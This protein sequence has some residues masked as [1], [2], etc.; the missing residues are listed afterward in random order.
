MAD[1]L[2]VQDAPITITVGDKQY[3][4]PIW[5]TAEL[6]PILSK[7]RNERVEALRKV[8]GSQKVIAR[9]AAYMLAK[10]ETV[11]LDPH[12]AH[13]YFMS[14]EGVDVC[15]ATSLKKTGVPESEIKEVL[16][17]LKFHQKT[18]LMV[19]VAGIYEPAEPPALKQDKKKDI[20]FGDQDQAAPK[21]PASFG[22]QG[23]P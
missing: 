23:N 17:K 7:I 10:E 3:T 20:G 4:F 11:Q 8:I 13:L 18:A 15:L 12:D 16:G 6:L 21:E 1:F 9:E 14:V 2:T 22:D 19:R 5:T